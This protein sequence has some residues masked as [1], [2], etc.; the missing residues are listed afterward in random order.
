VVK[1]LNFSQKQFGRDE[2]HLA[3]ATISH[4]FRWGCEVRRPEPLCPLP[5]S[6]PV[7]ALTQRSGLLDRADEHLSATKDKGANAARSDP[8]SQEWSRSRFDR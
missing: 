8:W 6:F 7:M 5:G 4:P 2:G 1:E 3:G